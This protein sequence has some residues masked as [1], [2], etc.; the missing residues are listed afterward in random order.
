MKR[1]IT[2]A[3]AKDKGKEFQKW[4]C[5][6]VSN[7]TKIPWGPP[8]TDMPIE[9]RASCQIG[10]DVRLESHV[11]KLFPFSVEC[12]R[13]ESWSIQEWI[14]Q[15]RANEAKGTDWLILAKKSNKNPVAFMDAIKFFTL[16]EEL[17]EL[18]IWKEEH[19]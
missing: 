7:L 15:A 1:T 2:R 5:K 12:K 11:K 19:D 14:D 6:M 4:A 18:R 17:A 16:L 8:G 10:C 3:A 13:Q 9:P